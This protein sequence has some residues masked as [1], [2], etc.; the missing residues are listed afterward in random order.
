[1]PPSREPVA[2][3][4]T[5]R[6]FGTWLPGDER[7]YVN[8]TQNEYGEPYKGFDSRRE[9]AARGLMKQPPLELDPA[10]RRVVD[11]S[12]REACE[13]RDWCV[14]ALN[15]RTNHVHLVVG[16][17]E[18]PAK[19]ALTLKARATR[20]LREQQLIAVDRDVWARGTSKRV[21]WNEDGLAIAVDYVLNRQ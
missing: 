10:M 9:E 4:L 5:W 11:L 18:S 19:I 14:S 6:T 16:A 3:L 21:V 17:T 2:F 12:I 8:D 15:V 1:M 20:S 7:G 13:Y